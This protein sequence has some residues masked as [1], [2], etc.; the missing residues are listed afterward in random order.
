MSP[1][2]GRG[3]G[4]LILALAAA[5][6]ALAAPSTA[7]ASAPAAEEPARVAQETAPDPL[8]DEEGWLSTDYQSRDPYEETNRFTLSINERID[9]LVFDPVTKLYR[10]VL[11]EVVRRGVHR[12]LANAN[13][14][15]IIVNKML[16][17]RFKETGIAVG[18]FALNS[19][20]G[21]GG[22]FDAAKEAGWVYDHADFGQTLAQWGSP[23]GPY[24]VMPLFGPS[25]ARDAFG[26]VVDLFFNPVTYFLGPVPQ[27]FSASGYGFSRREANIDMVR[28]RSP[29]RA[30]LPQDLRRRELAVEAR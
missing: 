3:P 4:A 14:P 27:L 18:R 24:L 25:T 12:V 13:S 28:P 11:P 6:L 5:L 30:L 9:W 10:L 19:T 2:P 22:L 29:R 8:D 7:Q 23:S 20:V 16:Q 26:D 1:R 21:F 17:L 15:A